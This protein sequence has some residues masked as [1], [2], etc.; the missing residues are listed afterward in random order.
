MMDAAD[1]GPMGA[2]AASPSQRRRRTGPEPCGPGRGPGL[3]DQDSALRAMVPAPRPRPDRHQRE[4]QRLGRNQ[5][6]D[7]AVACALAQSLF[8]LLDAKTRRASSTCGR[9][10]NRSTPSGSLH[11]ASNPPS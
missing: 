8:E 1:A 6:F 2:A 11:T 3:V 9:S 4:S 7:P 10:S 5:R